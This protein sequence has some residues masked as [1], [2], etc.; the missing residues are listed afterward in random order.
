M[1]IFRLGY[2]VHSFGNCGLTLPTEIG[3]RKCGG[4]LRRGY[5]LVRA[6][7]GERGW[8]GAESVDECLRVTGGMARGATRCL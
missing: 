3:L 5:C 8:V 2:L 7:Y 4:K 6:G 1:I